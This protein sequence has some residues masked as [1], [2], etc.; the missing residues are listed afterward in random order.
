MVFSEHFEGISGGLVEFQI[1]SIK[2][3]DRFNHWQKDSL[4]TANVGDA[5]YSIFETFLGEDWFYDFNQLEYKK[6]MELVKTLQDA[7]VVEVLTDWIL[8]RIKEDM[9]LNILCA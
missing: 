9:Y 8:K 1:S 5:A 7:N 4:F 2:V 3:V 6:A